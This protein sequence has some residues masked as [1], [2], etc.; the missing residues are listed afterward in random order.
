MFVPGSSRN[1]SNGSISPFL[2]G[3]AP[4]KGAVI[5]LNYVIML[6]NNIHDI[7]VFS[8]LERESFIYII[9]SDYNH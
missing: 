6:I 1:E 7:P 9:I 2:W 4:F 3:T 5:I 8:H